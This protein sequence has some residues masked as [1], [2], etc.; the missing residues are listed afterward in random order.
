VRG[1]QALSEPVWSVSLAEHPWL[2]ALER[3]H[4]HAGPAI[5]LL[6]AVAVVAA[7]VRRGWAMLALGVAALSEAGLFVVMTEAG[8]SGNPRYVLPALALACVPGGRRR[9]EPGGRRLRLRT[10]SG[11]AVRAGR[12]GAGGGGGGAPCRLSGCRAHRWAGK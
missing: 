9:G 3:V 7:L 10:P 4:S 12:R 11:G 6:M 2:H 8:F 1:R 5:E